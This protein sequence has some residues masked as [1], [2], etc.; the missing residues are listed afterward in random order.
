MNYIFE[1]QQVLFLILRFLTK[2]SYSNFWLKKMA[3]GFSG[4][5][6]MNLIQKL[7]EFHHIQERAFKK[8]LCW[9]S[10]DTTAYSF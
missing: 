10:Q 7:S 1:I 3:I 8:Q 9:T 2:I 6:T 4:Y 5:N